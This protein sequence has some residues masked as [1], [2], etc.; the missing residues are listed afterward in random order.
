MKIPF[1]LIVIK[2]IPSSRALLSRNKDFLS[3]KS[4]VDDNYAN[5]QK[6]GKARL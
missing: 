2:R 4:N 1:G 6:G 5:M 3:L